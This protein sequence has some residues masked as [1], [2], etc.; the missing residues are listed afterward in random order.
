MIFVEPLSVMLLG[1]KA[2]AI[3]HEKL[4]A[5]PNKMKPIELIELMDRSFNQR[6]LLEGNST[7]NVLHGAIVRIQ[8]EALELTEKAISG[9]PTEEADDESA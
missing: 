2:Q 7:A 4:D 5:K 9:K 1:G 8:R 3:L 6:R